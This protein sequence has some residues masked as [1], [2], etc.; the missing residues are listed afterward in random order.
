[1][2]DEP[3]L[4]VIQPITIDTMLN[5]NWLNNEL[6]YILVKNRAEFRYVSLRVNFGLNFGVCERSCTK[7]IKKITTDRLRPQWW[8]AI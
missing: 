4:S 8:Q 3:I 5:N 6:I 7:C 1:M 2:D